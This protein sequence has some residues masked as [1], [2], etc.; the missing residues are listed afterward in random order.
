[1]GT[2][3][4][5]K[6]ISIQSLSTALPLTAMQ[7]S[8]QTSKTLALMDI[9][10]DNTSLHSS[11]PSL[12][13]DLMPPMSVSPG[14][15]CP[16]TPMNLHR[17]GEQDYHIIFRCDTHGQQNHYGP[18]YVPHLRLTLT[19][20]LNSQT[21]PFHQFWLMGASHSHCEVSLPSILLLLMPFLPILLRPSLLITSPSLGH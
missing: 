13:A 2:L 18:Y 21:A 3:W 7:M 20:C 14:D 16:N 6:F 11:L 8:G 1:M 5:F 15:T 10:T 12:L 4:L 17:G 9:L 19:C